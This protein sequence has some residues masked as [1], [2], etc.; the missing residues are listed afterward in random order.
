[1]LTVCR[2]SDTICLKILLKNACRE[3][4]KVAGGGFQMLLGIKDLKSCHAN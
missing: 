1:M 4:I 3:N 2:K